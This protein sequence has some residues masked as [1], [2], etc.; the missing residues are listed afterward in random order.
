MIRARQLTL[1][2]L[3]GS[4]AVV[5]VAAAAGVAAAATYT[6]TETIPVPPASTYEGGGGGDG[7]AVA[8]SNTQVFNVFHHDPELEIACHLQATAEPCWSPEVITEPGTGDGFASSG[9]P[10]L[11]LDQ[12]TGR[13]YVYATRTSDNTGG[14]VCIATKEAATNTDPFCGFTALTSVGEAPT[15]SGIS[16][17]SDPAVV[18][19]R[20]YAFS[21]VYDEESAGTKNKLLCFSLVSFNACS[22]QPYSLA[23]TGGRD[24]DGA[25][26][27]PAVAAI[28][29]QVVVPMRLDVEGETEHQEF[30]CFNGQTQAACGGSWPVVSEEFYDSSYG[31]P[32]PLLTTSGALSGFCLPDGIDPC[33]SQTGAST[34]TPSG[35]TAAIAASS[36]WNGPAQTIGTRVYVP[37]GDSDSVSCFDYSKD[38]TCAEFPHAFS[39]LGLLYTVNSDPQ[40]PTCLWVNSDDGSGQIQN[41]DAFTTGSCGRG[42]IRVLASHLITAAASCTPSSY[43]S[44]QVTSPSSSSYTSGSIT[45]EDSGG[46]PIPG[47]TEVALNGSGTASLVGLNLNAGTGLPQ[48]VISL[49]GAPE[50]LGQVVVKLTWERAGASNPS[51]LNGGTYVALGDSYSSGEGNPTG[52]ISGTNVPGQDVC[53]RST[54]AYP[55]QAELALAYYSQ[56][57]SFHACSGAV[58]QDFYSPFPSDH[59]GANPS[60]NQPQLHWLGGALGTHASL[61][62]LTIGGNN[63][64]F[65]KAMEACYLNTVG[66]NLIPCQTEWNG[67]V[68]GAITTM[69]TNSPGSKES[70]TQLYEH[71]AA[72][73]PNAT[74]LVVGYPRFFPASPPLFCGTGALGSQFE[75]PQMQWINNE[76]RSMDNTIARAVRETLDPNVRYVE[77]YEAFRGHERCESEPWLNGIKVKEEVGSFHPNEKG[78]QALARLVEKAAG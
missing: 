75:R 55:F 4:L 44:L 32:Y 30:A 73:A 56:R 78:H 18:G 66:L 49:V 77:T 72:Q 42:V 38:E 17:I 7:W 69:G 67:A 13:L 2:L 12:T 64:H 65:A 20:M 51:C 27:P 70:L 41:F 11:W 53:H 23:T 25:Y 68:N 33:Y 59:G 48:F 3:A 1:F 24:F 14:V 21:Y 47:A 22:G 26:P 71:V 15:N 43:L 76:E 10:G 62:T 61:V 6:A 63:A 46:N 60:E 35:M 31:A 19:Q 34:A 36:G 16:A 58:T 39:N 40:R 9:Q 57:F 5:V 45:F 54:W 29:N 74:I 28:G 8:L 37:N 50:G 52:Y